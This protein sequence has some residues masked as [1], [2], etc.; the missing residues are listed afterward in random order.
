MTPACGCLMNRATRSWASHRSASIEK[1]EGGVYSLYDEE[2]G[3]TRDYSQEE[4]LVLGEGKW[5]GQVGD[6][7]MA[8]YE[9]LRVFYAGTLIGINPED[10]TV[11][12]PV[13]SSPRT[14]FL[15]GTYLF[16]FQVVAMQRV[17]TDHTTH[18]FNHHALH[19]GP[20]QW[21]GGGLSCFSLECVRAKR[22]CACSR[23]TDHS[24]CTRQ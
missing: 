11:E 4:V 8:R 2:A 14:F 3:T 16:P 12:W 19:H 7:V 1:V 20:W 15:R 23:A 17:H 10:V 5:E 21:A 24:G 9:G 13:N 22:K 18:D 6:R